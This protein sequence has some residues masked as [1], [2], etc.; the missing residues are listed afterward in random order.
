MKIFVVC[1]LVLGF[2]MACS[3]VSPV[4]GGSY[5]L[6]DSNDPG[7]PT[8]D[9]IPIVSSGEH[10]I[11]SGDPELAGL[12]PEV[13]ILIHGHA[14]GSPDF[15][16]SITVSADGY[17]DGDTDIRS[18][19][20]PDCSLPDAPPNTLTGAG[21][22]PRLFVFHAD[23]EIATPEQFRNPGGVFYEYFPRSPHPHHSGGVHVFTWNRMVRADG[24]S[25]FSFQALLFDNGDVITQYLSGNPNPGSF[26]T[27]GSQLAILAE[28]SPQSYNIVELAHSTYAARNIDGGSLCV[29]NDNLSP[30]L[31]VLFELETRVIDSSTNFF[32]EKFKWEVGVKHVFS[33]ALDGQTI[34]VARESSYETPFNGAVI[35]DAGSLNNG[36]RFRSAEGLP[37]FM[38]TGTP[39][40]NEGDPPRVAPPYFYLNKVTVETGRTAFQINDSTT[41]VAQD[42][43]FRQDPGRPGIRGRVLECFDDFSIPLDDGSGFEPTTEVALSLHLRDSVID[44]SIDAIGLENIGERIRVDGCE[45]TDA[46]GVFVAHEDAG[47]A[48]VEILD[49]RFV[50]TG[51]LLEAGPGFEA[52]DD[53]LTRLVLRRC[54]FERDATL[55]G[56]FSL[57]EANPAIC[58]IEACT[59]I[60]FRPDNRLS[61]LDVSSLV[62][63]VGTS[64][65]EIRIANS[66]FVD[67]G[68]RIREDRALALDHCTFSRSSS[69][70]VVRRDTSTSPALVFTNCLFDG[71]GSEDRLIAAGFVINS[72]SRYNLFT[73][74]EPDVPSTQGNLFDADPLLQ[75]LGY[76]GGPTRTLRPARSSPAVD[77]GDPDFLGVIDQRGEPRVRDGDDDGTPVTDIGAVELGLPVNPVVT[78]ALDELNDPGSGLSLREA[79]VE[80]GPDDVITFD[81]A[82]D[83]ASIGLTLGTLEVPVGAVIDA[84]NLA[85]GIRID[86]LSTVDAFQVTAGRTLSLTKLRI[87]ELA[88]GVVLGNEAVLTATDC[89]FRD[90]GDRDSP[91]GAISAGDGATITLSR[92]EI[93]D[94]EAK[95]GGAI[96]TGEGAALVMNDS[97]LDGNEAGDGGAIDLGSGSS[98]QI[99]RCALT[100]NIAANGDGGAILTGAL[101]GSSQ[102]VSSTVGENHADGDGGGLFLG[103]GTVEIRYA[104]I[105]RNTGGGGVA[106]TLGATSYYHSI[107]A[108]NEANGALVNV[109]GGVSEGANLSDNDAGVFTVTTPVDRVDSHPALTPLGW[110]GGPAPSYAPLAH[111]PAVRGG[112]EF[113]NSVPGTP[114]LDQRGLARAVNGIPPDLGAVQ[115]AAPIMVTTTA[116]QNQNPA[117]AQVSIREAVRDCPDGGRILFDPELNGATLNLN[118]QI[119]LNG[120]AIQIDATLLPRGVTLDRNG[121]SSRVVNIQSAGSLSMHAV[122]CTGGDASLAGGGIRNAGRLVLTRAALH[123]NVAANGGG[124][125]LHAGAS[126][127]LEQC[128]LSGNSSP[129]PGGAIL[130]NSDG[131]LRVTHCTIA[132]NES[133]TGAG[134]IHLDGSPLVFGH[135]LFAE[136]FGGRERDN[137]FPDKT[138]LVTSLGHSLVDTDEWKFATGDKFA[139]LRPGNLVDAGGYAPCH[140]IDGK[141]AATDQGGP[142]AALFGGTDQRGW[143]RVA[144]SKIDIGAIESSGYSDWITAHTDPGAPRGLEEDSEGDG[145]LNGVEYKLGLDPERQ[146]AGS[147]FSF[148]TVMT[149]GGDFPGVRFA[150]LGLRDDV[151]LEVWL[152]DDLSTWAPIYTT[153]DVFNDYVVSSG[154]AMTVFDRFDTNGRAFFRFRPLER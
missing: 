127:V 84:G 106:G 146:D 86:A 32:S 153:G 64:L 74:T 44:G 99:E 110:H 96:G 142:L 131:P 95:R 137:L 141:S 19:P 18:D 54:E 1:R 144:N 68:L 123:G 61:L 67:A 122:S 56:S 98:F 51:P 129:G 45:I 35:L 126:T 25:V 17:I 102:L 63:P 5:D 147:A 124:G 121:G 47:N 66:T 29:I 83:G 109:T 58:E 24:G 132:G 94:C 23:L 59:V 112:W 2:F 145:V 15:F 81:P 26:Y 120:K 101:V 40:R 71:G 46:R 53:P 65:D 55:A 77:G 27:I 143:R 133:D 119:R 36:V 100:N 12:R 149:P 97:W 7:G 76:H 148:R 69:S 9:W 107:V 136:N 87:I 4:F 88:R 14:Y 39:L 43:T 113:W 75:P 33:S 31:A 78:T 140:L 13:P 11:A 48:S 103:G 21:P 104:T 114:E 138:P 70:L 117:G 152:S 38:S 10:L 28:I 150:P 72:S 6:S 52:S 85:G 128:T 37:F 93:R 111:S 116:D 20:A 139:E 49:S 34:N 60:N 125:L 82:L 135:V 151:E 22:D 115:L 42:C 91:G 79:L 3:C 80:A 57:F 8:Y 130:A 105:H 41:F 134:G 30:N 108:S 62:N 154:G 16:P 90:L 73:H 89:I 92:C 118:N 50:D